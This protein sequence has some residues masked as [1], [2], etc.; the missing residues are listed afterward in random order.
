MK[1]VLITGATGLI[2]SRI[3]EACLNDGYK[4]HYLTTSKGK[5]QL[6]TTKQGFY[7]N[8][9]NGDIDEAAFNGVGTIINLAGAPIAN[10]WTE[11]YKDEIIKS[12]VQ[13]LDLLKNTLSRIDHQVEHL[14]S[15][16]AIGIYPDSE[17]IYYD[18][19]SKINDNSFLV[20]VV[21]KW[22]AAADEL[23]EVGL[24]VAKV[25]IGIVLSAE[26]GAMEKLIKPIKAFVGS[27]LGSGDQW[28]SWIHL[29]D[30]VGI[31]MHIL[32]FGLE[33]VYNG[34]A[35]NPV[36]QKYLT[37]AIA[38]EID[39]PIFLPAVPEFVLKMILGEMHVIVTSGQRVSSKKIQDKGYYFQFH[40]LE[41]ALFDLLQKK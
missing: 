13:S 25:R 32:K 37:K 23:S 31:F 21:K 39:R 35:P 8:P 18:E 38:H 26:G 27:P 6:S 5:I 7:W 2:G 11:S 36:T 14:I 22:E 9:D 41:A 3:S 33:G 28:Q 16:S 20:E 29:N 1:T 30:L 15:A 4:V 19:N 24:T 10:R 17:T 12:R 40:Q 34:V